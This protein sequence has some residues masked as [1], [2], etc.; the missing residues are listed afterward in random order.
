MCVGD[1]K[2]LL[3]PGEL[4]RHR[5]RSDARVGPDCEATVFTESD[6]TADPDAVEF[7][8]VAE[9]YA[10]FGLEQEHIPFVSYTPPPVRID[11]GALAGF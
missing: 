7:D 9:L 11:A 4:K 2:P 5:F 3:W 6:A 1:E 8:L 10:W